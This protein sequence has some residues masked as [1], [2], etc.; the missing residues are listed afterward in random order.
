MTHNLTS[1][2]LKRQVHQLALPVIGGS[3]FHFA[4]EF[5]DMIWVGRLGKEA[6]ASISASQFVVWIFLATA[7]IPAIGLLAV[8]AR[9]H[10]EGDLQQ[11][12][13]LASSGVG[14]GLLTG[15]FFLL[16]AA[17][18]LDP[19]VGL[20]GLQGEIHLHALNYA[21]II[22][23]IAPVFFV[24]FVGEKIFH[25]SGDT[26]TP[27]RVLSGAIALNIILDPLL[28]FGWLGFPRLGVEGAAV[29]TVLSETLY[30]VVL[31]IIMAR[32]G[33]YAPQ[34]RALRFKLELLWKV[35]R[36]GVPQS[37]TGIIF[38]LVYMILTRIL[39]DFGPEP[40]AALGIGHRVEYISWLLAMGY[41]TA[42]AT[43]VGQNLGA[44]DIDRVKRGVR[45]ALLAAVTLSGILA[46]VYFI[47]AE[48]CVRIFTGE[49]EVISTGSTYLRILAFSQVFMAVELVLDGAFSGAG[50]TLPLMTISVPLSVARVPLALLFV[51]YVT[52]DV[53]GVWWAIT[54]STIVRGILMYFWW[55]LGRWQKVKI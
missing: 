35:V 41:S 37:L 45:H 31:L 17:L 22:L 21:R 9:R 54:I 25:A 11:A 1:G 42:A 7:G 10:G 26:A 47:G 24:S 36:I 28:I 15:V 30:M 20:M 29:A 13:S 32:R 8:L 18:T 14:I 46:V 12:R 6:L 3:L 33:L 2:S 23:G 55:S 27:F 19:F 51:R 44:G 48:H 52:H 43:I 40:I 49:A 50:N 38:S 39:T 4:F 16:V 53:S 5:I 34:L